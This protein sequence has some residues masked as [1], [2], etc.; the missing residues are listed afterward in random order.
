M[1]NLCNTLT[2]SIISGYSCVKGKIWG[3][4]FDNNADSPSPAQKETDTVINIKKCED[5]VA[6]TRNEYQLIKNEEYEYAKD[7][8]LIEELSKEIKSVNIEFDETCDKELKLE[9]DNIDDLK[10]QILSE[11][12]DI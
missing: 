1:G 10:H 11:D 9:D 2:N 3:S 12:E 6:I 8:L 5:K 7:N 4:K